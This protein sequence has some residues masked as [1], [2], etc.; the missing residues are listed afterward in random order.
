MPRQGNPPVHEQNS[1]IQE[2]KQNIKDAMTGVAAVLGADAPR[3]QVVFSQ[4]YVPPV[5]EDS[6]VRPRYLA[7]LA[8][9]LVNR[10]RPGPKG[11]TLSA[12]VQ[13]LNQECGVRLAGQAQGGRGALLRY[14]LQPAMVDGLY[15]LYIDRFMQDLNAAAWRKGLDATQNRDFHAA[16]AGRAALLAASLEGV[17]KVP[18]LSASLARIDNL[19]QKAVDEN[20]GLAAAVFEF[21]ELKNGDS[22]ARA[23][24]QLRV[25][26]AS[27]RY[28]RAADAHA[29]AQRRLAQE[30]RKY[31]GPGMDDDSLLFMAAWVGRRESAGAQAKSALQRC[32][33][34]L[35]D[36]AARC[37]A[38][39]G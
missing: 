29:E 23:A 15:K 10:Y 9:W 30:I 5:T 12:S 6:T 19:A 28:R 22:Q 1:P 8:Q 33:A 7:S 27:A 31:A 4:E 34:A 32:A 39:G 14:A 3:S 16:L 36:M 11:G 37:Q 20:A 38:A 26:G 35:R 13:S 18:D 21:D 25:D 24:A 17:L 2:I